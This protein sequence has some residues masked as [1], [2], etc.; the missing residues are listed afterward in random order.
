MMSPGFKF[1][2]R[3]FS[4]HISNKSRLHVPVNVIGANISFSLSA[5]IQ[6]TLSVRRPDLKCHLVLTTKYRRKV[7]TDAMLT[8]LEEIFKALMEKWEGRLVEFN[9][10]RDHVHLLLQYTPQTEPSKLINNLKTVSSRYLRK[11]FVTEVNRVYWKDVLWTS[12]YFIASCGG[13][14]VEGSNE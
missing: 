2:R 1:G 5:A 8:R 10:E 7:L 12:G 13:V 3:H 4:S 14:T 9:G 11:E 6:L